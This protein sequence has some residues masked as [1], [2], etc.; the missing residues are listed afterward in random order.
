MHIIVHVNG[1]PLSIQRVNTFTCEHTHAATPQEKHN[2]WGGIVRLD[3]ALDQLADS[4]MARSW[5]PHTP[6][7]QTSNK[8][9]TS[10]S[11]KVQ[12]VQHPDNF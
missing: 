9:D 12:I 2:F 7:Q 1:H 3:P 5:R 10:A 11:Q 6:L 8:L 4:H